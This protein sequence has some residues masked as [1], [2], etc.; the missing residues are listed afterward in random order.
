MPAAHPRSRDSGCEARRERAR[1]RGHN[2]QHCTSR[3]PPSASPA[4]ARPCCIHIANALPNLQL[5]SEW[6]RP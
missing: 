5:N 3:A 4:P 2:G 6:L 1:N